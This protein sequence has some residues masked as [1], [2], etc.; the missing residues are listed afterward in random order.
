MSDFVKNLLMWIII[1]MVL[2]S[3]FNHYSQTDM[4]PRE[5]TYSVFL[6]EV[7]RGNVERVEIQET[8]GGKTITGQTRGGDEFRVLAPRDD[9]LIKDLLDNSVEIEPSHLSSG[10]LSSIFSSVCCR[11]WSWSDYGSTSCVRCRAGPVAGA[12]R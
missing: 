4:Q 6:D 5:M 10:R 3:V 1:A 11:C 7:R 9:G 2:M 8:T 12:A